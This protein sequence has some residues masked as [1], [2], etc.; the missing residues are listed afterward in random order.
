M[1]KLRMEKCLECN[2][3]CV[4][5]YL[6]SHTKLKHN[7]TLKEYYDDHYHKDGDESCTECGNKTRFVSLD[8]G[9][10]PTCSKKC[11]YKYRSNIL[12]KKYGVTNQFQLKEIKDR[13]K[14]TLRSKYGVE[15]TSQLAETKQKKIDTC[16]KNFGVDHP[17]QSQVISDKAKVT[18]FERYGSENVMHN[19]EIA[20][21]CILHGAGRV[22]A[23]KYKTKFG[24]TILVQ[25]SYER[26]FVRFCEK[27]DIPIDDGPFLNYDFDGKSHRYFIDFKIDT[28]GITRLVEIKSTY[29]Y[30][31]YKDVIDIKNKYAKEYCKERGW[32]FH[33]IINDN[34]KKE[35]NLK[36]FDVVL[37]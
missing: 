1:T 14:A 29:W 27:N 26:L 30:E 23:K 8:V 2:F 15:N 33:F 21:R 32:Q 35:I 3:E 37:E 24:N 31:Q 7:K 25:G 28:G 34:N 20:Q 9:Y 19:A 5:N 10:N 18:N 17:G 12:Y 36:K 16:F 11:A 22:S 4:L 6:G 13:S